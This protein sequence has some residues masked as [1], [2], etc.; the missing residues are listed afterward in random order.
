MTIEKVI[1]F[2][3][4][5]GHPNVELMT[6]GTGLKQGDT[7]T[8]VCPQGPVRIRL[9][10]E[11]AYDPLTW[12]TGDAPIYVLRTLKKGEGQFWCGGVE[13]KERWGMKGFDVP[14]LEI[15][16]LKAMLK[17]PKNGPRKL[18]SKDE[19]TKAQRD[20]DTLKKRVPRHPTMGHQPFPH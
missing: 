9:S 15:Q 1:C 14:E 20:L 3:Y 6:D 7:F 10:P 11:D 17:P 4:I 5:E 19:L 8:F 12:K 16:R 2:K 18:Q 13:G